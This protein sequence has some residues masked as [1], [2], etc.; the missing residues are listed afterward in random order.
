LDAE[1]DRNRTKGLNGS[2]VAYNVVQVTLSLLDIRAAGCT[3]HALHRGSTHEI[4]RLRLRRTNQNTT[5]CSAL[6]ISQV[7]ANS[8]NQRVTHPANA[9]QTDRN[10]EVPGPENKGF[11]LDQQC[12]S[13]AHHLK[14]CIETMERRRNAKERSVAFL[15]GQW[16]TVNFLWQFL[17]STE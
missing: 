16:Q 11:L 5:N 3:G 9:Q 12:Y 2:E 10:P 4:A 7:L 1:V 14:C 17:I 8:A 13:L 6:F 15:A